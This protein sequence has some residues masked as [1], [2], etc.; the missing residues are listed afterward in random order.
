MRFSGVNYQ[1]NSRILA[2]QG[3]HDCLGWMPPALTDPNHFVD[4]DKMILHALEVRFK[5]RINRSPG[6]PS[7]P[8][9]ISIIWSGT[10][11]GLLG[12]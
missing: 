7:A 3:H 10:G 11:I 1:A 9:V 2:L 8:E 5:N 6:F 4:S 12:A